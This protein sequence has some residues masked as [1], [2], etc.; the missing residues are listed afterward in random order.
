MITPG[1]KLP[2]ELGGKTFECQVLTRRQLRKLIVLIQSSA[3]LENNIEGVLN[4]MDLVDE[5][6]TLI[7]PNLTEAE[8]DC[9]QDADVVELATEVIKSHQ[10]S[11]SLKKRS[12]SQP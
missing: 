2:I 7:A 11:D 3:E 8:A 4:A 5:I 1:E 6:L 10:V 9:L 12:E